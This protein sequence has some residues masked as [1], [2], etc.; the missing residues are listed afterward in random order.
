MKNEQLNTILEEL[1]FAGI[2]EIQK[3]TSR[4]KDEG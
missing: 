2:A 4:M 1:F 3:F